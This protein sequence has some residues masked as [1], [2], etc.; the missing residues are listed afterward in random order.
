MRNL[1]AGLAALL[2]SLV[3]AEC[4]SVGEYAISNNRIPY[5]E[6]IN[7]TSA[8]QLLLNLVRARDFEAP[9]FITPAEINSANSASATVAANPTGIGSV[10]GVVGAITGTAQVSDSPQVRYS[11]LTGV[12][13]VRQISTPMNLG[14]IANLE[15]SGWPHTALFQWTVDRL[16][17]RVIDYYRTVDTIYFLYGLG[18]ITFDS[19]DKEPE[20][21]IT[22]HKRGNVFDDSLS[23]TPEANGLACVNEHRTADATAAMLWKNLVQLCGAKGAPTRLVLGPRSQD[24]TRL[25]IRTVSAYAALRE[26]AMD[27]NT[28]IHFTSPD[29]VKAIINANQGHAC[30]T[31][32][33][34]YFSPQDDGDTTFAKRSWSEH[35]DLVI[36]QPITEA[37]ALKH[38]RLGHSRAYILVAQSDRPIPNA[39]VSISRKGRW[40]AIVEDD[41]VSKRNFALLSQILTVQSS[42]APQLSPTAVVAPTR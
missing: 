13:L 42:S 25:P 22:Y 18:A 2:M 12:D 6:A 24:K 35:G 19:S 8:Q 23:D 36:N 3:L 16:T 39:Y 14:M 33:F 9:T 1:F 11:T 15:T 34:Y 26:A 38:R 28:S 10:A 30:A 29:N 41:I 27:R 5:N 21:V 31:G 7:A 37:N 20:L 4:S 17:P 40:Y 32:E